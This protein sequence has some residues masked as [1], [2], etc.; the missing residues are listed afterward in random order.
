LISKIIYLKVRTLPYRESFVP[1]LLRRPQMKIGRLNA[2]ALIIFAFRAV[3]EVF[4]I[5]TTVTQ[6]T[7]RS[8]V[9][10]PMVCNFI[11]LMK[12]VFY[13]DVAFVIVKVRHEAMKY[14]D[15]YLIMGLT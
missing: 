5:I 7:S 1:S 3:P 2:I 10:H 11:A 8:H 15:I 4:L 13:Q 12:N 14:F 6:H 9:M